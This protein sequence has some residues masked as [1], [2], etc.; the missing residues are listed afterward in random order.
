[1]VSL[2]KPLEDN[3]FG[4]PFNISDGLGEMTPHLRNSPNRLA[5]LMFI[6]EDRHIGLQDVSQMLI[7]IEPNADLSRD[8]WVKLAMAVYDEFSEF[9]RE[10]FEAWSRRSTSYDPDD[11]DAMWNSMNRGG[12]ITIATLVKK[13][14]E[15]GWTP[16]PKTPEEIAQ[17]E[18]EA[19]V[20]QAYNAVISEQKAKEKAEQHLIASE[21]A[22]S[23]FESA[24]PAPEN[25]SYLMNKQVKPHGVKVDANG[26]LIIPITGTQSPFIGKFQSLQLIYRNGDKRF[27]KGGKKSGG[28]YIIQQIEDAPIIICEG[29]ATGA[30]IAEHYANNCTVICAFDA[31]NLIH[32]AKAFRENYSSLNIIIAADN[33]RIDENGNPRTENPGVKAATR[34]AQAVVGELVIPVF[35][36]DEIGSDWNDRY[37]LDIEVGLSAEE[38]K[39][40]FQTLNA[41][42]IS[43]NELEQEPV[44][45]PLVVDLPDV[46]PFEF[47]LLPSSLEPWLKDIQARMQCPADFLAV[48]AMVAIAGLIGR[49]VG[50]YPK[51]FDDWLVIPNLWGAMI[52]RPSIMKTPALSEVMKPIHRLAKLAEEE[53]QQILVDHEV[54]NIA[55]EA[56]KKVAEDAIK[57][58]AKSSDPLKMEVAKN[59]YRLVLEAESNSTPTEKRYIVND[60][61]VEALG[62]KLNENP[63]GVIL[64]R[65]ELAGWIRGLDREDKANDRAFYL[66]CFNG[67]GFYIYDRVGR[68]TLKIESTTLSIIGGIQ[69]SVLAPHIAQS[70]NNGTGNDGFI[71][72]FQLAV[73]PD[74]C[75]E[76]VNV[77]RYPDKVAK[78][79]AFEL[80]KRLVTLP[81]R[82]DEEGSVIGL[83]FDQQAQQV[84]NSWREQL[85]LTIRVKDIH[86]ALESHL[87]KYRSLLPSIALLLELADNPE[88]KSVGV[89]ATNKAVRWC[90]YLQSH[91]NRIYA[92]AVDNDILAAQKVLENR[93]KLGNPFKPREI[94]QK[95]WAG[96]KTTT[97]VK[98]ALSVLVEHGYLIEQIKTHMTGGRPSEIYQW[99]TALKN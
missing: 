57:K 92:G 77:D 62:I 91:M 58:A 71:Q 86:P 26:T 68:G 1:M 90:E 47:D 39:S 81:E 43:S 6:G 17:L 34:A 89:V 93:E 98:A 22:Q 12:G 28:Y 41:S 83:R 38:I 8:D 99:N 82:R 74:D 80:F 50:I 85:E 21:E 51:Q 3:V 33:D 95:G 84:F 32:V 15:S 29:F 52:G 55:L 61:T 4:I 9:G 78:E 11:F 64:L 72:R 16:L 59:N 24:K 37:L 45:I 48:G 79:K 27:T 63:N 18:A 53:Y 46:R 96:L 60:A 69:P 42:S 44:I 20:R 5:D 25:H 2:V 40:K 65:D 36:E 14:F 87:A 49:K 31:G 35:A 13:A 7:K 76:W 75:K 97:E 23:I 19:K 67:S 56:E 10:P 94:A 54:D 70:I 88:A 30:T 66:E 73:Y